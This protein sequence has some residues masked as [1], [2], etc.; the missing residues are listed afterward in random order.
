[1]RA[2]ASLRILHTLF[3]RDE[4]ARQ[5]LLLSRVFY[6]F[7]PFFRHDILDSYLEIILL[8]IFNFML[9]EIM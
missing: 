4:F 3:Q 2:A 5:F 9:N 8:I 6:K 1:M 7:L